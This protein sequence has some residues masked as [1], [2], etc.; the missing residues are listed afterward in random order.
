MYT[1]L[2][3]TTTIRVDTETHA[4]LVELSE[5]TGKSLIATVR[6]AA[7]ALHRQRFGVK[8]ASELAKLRLDPAAWS[9]YLAEA[10]TT[11]VTDGL[12]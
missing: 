9:S 3:S 5:S 11:L 1:Q 10:E 8:V 12:D 4:Q 2:V 6:D 7:E